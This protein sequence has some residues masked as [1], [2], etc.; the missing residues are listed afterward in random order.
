MSALPTA[1][2]VT[3]MAA[4]SNPYPIRK[5]CAV[6]LK[7]CVEGLGTRD[8]ATDGCQGGTVPIVQTNRADPA[9]AEQSPSGPSHP[10]LLSALRFGVF[11]QRRIR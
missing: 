6:R 10:T 8:A 7:T 4:S 3:E 9:V 5:L 1:P 2:R 11:S